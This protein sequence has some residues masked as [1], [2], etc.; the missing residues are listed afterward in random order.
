MQSYRVVAVEDR[1]ASQSYVS[2]GIVDPQI[3][4]LLEDR[5]VDYIHV[6]DT[7]AGCFDFR[8]ERTSNEAEAT[9]S[10]TSDGGGSNE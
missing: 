6:R 5:A 4:Q 7:D 10:R 8:I 3:Q 1:I 2:N 9:Q